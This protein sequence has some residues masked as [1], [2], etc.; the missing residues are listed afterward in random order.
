MALI[1]EDEMTHT[2]DVSFPIEEVADPVA[3]LR[4]IVAAR[5]GWPE[6]L[7]EL[8]SVFDKGRPS[9]YYTDIRKPLP[10]VPIR[11][12]LFDGDE[13]PAEDAEGWVTLVALLRK[14]TKRLEAVDLER[15]QQARR[16]RFR[17]GE[18]GAEGDEPMPGV[19]RSQPYTYVLGGRHG[20]DV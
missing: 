12:M 18:S 17:Y 2:F 3:L 7:T 1:A 11:L 10:E 4:H 8:W 19:L 15:V 9:H 14:P 16:W 13:L 6:Y 20:D 5:Y